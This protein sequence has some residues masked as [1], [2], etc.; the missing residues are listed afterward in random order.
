MKKSSNTTSG[1]KTTPNNSKPSTTSS[2]SKNRP[3][4]DPGPQVKK[5]SSNRKQ[6]DTSGRL[7]STPQVDKVW[8]KQFIFSV[9]TSSFWQISNQVNP[10]RSSNST[11]SNQSFYLSRG[12]HNT[13]DGPS[14]LNPSEERGRPIVVPQQVP[15]PIPVQQRSYYSQPVL[16]APQEAYRP[17]SLPPY[18]YPVYPSP[19]PPYPYAPYSIPYPPYNYDPYAYAPMVTTHLI[20]VGLH[21]YLLPCLVRRCLSGSIWVQIGNPTVP[22]RISTGTTIQSSSLSLLVWTTLCRMRS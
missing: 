2:T 17:H 7:V 11:S 13:D 9:L 15:L 21:S 12:L 6:N 16:V 14:A 19:I 18:P 10:P 3:I 1:K 8:Y 20:S 4:S 22:R 5:V